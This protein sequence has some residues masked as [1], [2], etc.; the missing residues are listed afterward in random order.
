[1]TKNKEKVVENIW[2]LKSKERVV[3]NKKNLKSII[4]ISYKK[5]D[6]SINILILSQSSLNI[7]LT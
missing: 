2:N 4:Y 5:L 1:M 7:N 6:L 3:E